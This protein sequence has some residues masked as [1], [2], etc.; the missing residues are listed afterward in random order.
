MKLR[1]RELYADG[2]GSG[3]HLDHLSSAQN[4]QN[5]QNI[6]T[7]CTKCTKWTKYIKKNTYSKESFKIT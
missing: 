7:K 1:T 4:V 6:Q 5:K 2:G 3:F